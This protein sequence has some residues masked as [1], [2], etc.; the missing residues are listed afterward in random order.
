MV[1]HWVEDPGVGNSKLP[2]GTSNNK[3]IKMIEVREDG[4]R[5]LI[6]RN[7]FDEYYKDRIERGM[8]FIYSNFDTNILLVEWK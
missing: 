3:G 6:P 5:L 4:K 2:L 1:E 7:R 8:E